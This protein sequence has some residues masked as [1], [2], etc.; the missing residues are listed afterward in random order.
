M[1]KYLLVERDMVIPY[2]NIE[3]QN[4]VTSNLSCLSLFLF[5]VAHCVTRHIETRTS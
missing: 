3:G 2:D 1:G 5:F 4:V